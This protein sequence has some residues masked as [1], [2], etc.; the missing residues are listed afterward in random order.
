MTA[1]AE[2]TPAVVFH[3]HIARSKLIDA[4]NE[5]D[6]AVRNR[7]RRLGKS[8][9]EM[10]GD[11]LVALEAVAAG[12]QYS[13]V[14]KK[15][16]DELVVELREMGLLRSTV[17]HSCMTV[18]EINGGMSALYSN[19]QKST[20]FGRTGLFLSLS[21]TEDC[22]SRLKEIASE[23]LTLGEPAIRSAVVVTKNSASA[24]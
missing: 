20:P 22:A 8:T 11:N 15:R 2:V 19:V 18:V 24:D 9:K 4:Y 3:L 14:I 13:K 17:V 12:P 21:E 10:M 5:A 23:L 16:V 6:L 1:M 7:L